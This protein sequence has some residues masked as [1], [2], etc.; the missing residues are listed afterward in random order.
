[1]LKVLERSGMQDSYLNIIKAIYCKPIA[2]IKLNGDILQT[3]PLKSRTRQ[4]YPLSAYLI[5]IVLKLSPKTIR[6]Q[7]EIKGIQLGKKE[8]QVSLFA[9][10]IIVY[11]TDPKNSTRELLQLKNNFSKVPGYKLNSN[12]SVDFVYTNDI[13]AEEEIRE[14]VPFTIATNSIKYFG[15]TLTK[16]C[17]RPVLQQ[18]QVSYE[19]NRRR[20][21]KMEKSPM[22]M[23][24]QN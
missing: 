8:I 11:M 13:Q 3:I 12:K 17:E 22:L 2:Y 6:H 14:T 19:R 23:D 9:D 16:K 15:V 1:V 20:T 10:D 21:Q 5:N 18:L 24:W 7:K 4:G